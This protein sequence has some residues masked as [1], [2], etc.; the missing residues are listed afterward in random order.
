MFF[1]G[2][3]G[4]GKTD[5]MENSCVNRRFVTTI[6]CKKD[7]IKHFVSKLEQGIGFRP[8]FSTLNKSFGFA[9]FIH[10]FGGFPVF[11]SINVLNKI[12]G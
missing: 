5:V 7:D 12:S 10:E 11:P 4:S 2:K 9:V 1:S 8:S 3:R 6:D